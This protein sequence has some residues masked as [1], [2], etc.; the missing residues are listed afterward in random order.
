MALK[1]EW[2]GYKVK[3]R[4]RHANLYPPLEGPLRNRCDVKSKILELKKILVEICDQ[5]YVV[6][7]GIRPELTLGVFGRA[8]GIR[9]ERMI[10]WTS[11]EL[12][13]LGPTSVGFSIPK[14]CA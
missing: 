3:R 9:R 6:C 4:R 14:A 13:S 12:S 1:V 5:I 11:A 7:A 10:G 8:E 2:R